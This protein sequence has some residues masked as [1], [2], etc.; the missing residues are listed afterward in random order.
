METFIWMLHTVSTEYPEGFTAKLGNSYEYAAEPTS[1]DQRLFKLGFKTMRY[2]TLAD[3]VTID[4]TKVP[5]VN[6]A[7]LEAFYKIHRMWKTFIYPHVIYGNVNVRFHKPLVIPP[8]IEGGGGAVQA[9]TLE[10]IE[11]P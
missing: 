8:G 3:G 2:F 10:L 6:M 11:Q 9:F 5:V 4:P 1:V 7:A